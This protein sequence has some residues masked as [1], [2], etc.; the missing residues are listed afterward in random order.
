VRRR[1]Q[2][3]LAG[4][5]RP[6]PFAGIAF[7]AVAVAGC[8]LLIYPLKADADPLS[9]D[10]LYVPAILLV[11]AGWG[12]RLGILT[13]LASLLAFDFF[14]VPPTL[15]FTVGSDAAP[16]IVFAVAAVAAT[17]VAGL[18][19][20]VRVAE[21]RER[22]RAESRARLVAAADEERRRVV[23]DL[24]DGAQQRL[25][26]AVI[27]LKL[28]RRALEKG[29]QDAEELVSEGLQQ[30]EQANSELRELAHGILP[31]VLTRGGL[32]AGV[33]SLTSRVSLP[34]TIDVCAERFPPAVEATAY[35]V[36]SEAL[37]NAV[38]HSRADR[39]EVSARVEDGALRVEVR[40]DGAGGA[41]LDRGSGLLGLRD[42]LDALDGE[43]LIESPPGGGTLLG[44]VL[45]VPVRQSPADR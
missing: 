4:E 31:S 17:F 1:F 40:D 8:T 24:H 22:A 10:V 16:L 21:E 42:R 38:K 45:P 25:V 43:L 35:F 27:N 11:A 41:R 2:S 28:A 26:H 9:L 30:A 14:H 19:A 37:T 23:R 12:A 3:W 32:R 7:A 36:I 6:S 44:A 5:L 20:R 34:V 33:E 15:E 13:T 29:N 18:T 39:A